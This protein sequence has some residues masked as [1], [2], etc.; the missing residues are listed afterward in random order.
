[1]NNL[2]TYE[3][4]LF[5]SE[6]NEADVN[7]QT[8]Q[9]A[10]VLVGGSIG[11]KGSFPLFVSG[12]MASIFQTGNDKEELVEKKKRMN[13]QLSPG[14][15]KYYGMSYKVIELTPSKRKDVDYLIA[16][17][18]KSENDT[19][20]V[21]ESINESTEVDPRVKKECISRLSDFFRVSPNALS[22]LKFDGKD[23]IKDVTKCLNATSYEG[24]EQ[25]Y[26]VAIKSVKRDLGINESHM[27]ELKVS[28]AGVKELLKKIYDNAKLMKALNF[29]NFR[30]VI[31]T[32]L[33]SDQNEIDELEAEIK[34]LG[35]A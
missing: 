9:F 8:D 31:D 35:F 33:T 11:S 6:L 23:P 13:K 12:Q 20:V 21:S 28:S 32:V 24:A 3:D 26:L 16:Q 30:D 27:N 19:A 29:K 10:L 7:Y 25:Y 14:E 2:K 34:E 1:M 5:E 4:F 18:S 22:H 17:Q 15:K